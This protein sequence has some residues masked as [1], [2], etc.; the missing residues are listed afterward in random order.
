[1]VAVVDPAAELRIEIGAAA[2]PGVWGGFIQNDAATG[3]GERHRRCKP[4]EARPD[5]MHATRARRSPHNTPWRNTSQSL[6]AVDT[7]TRSVGSRHSE[8]SD[9]CHPG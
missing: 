1:M 2:S 8:R 6:S 3:L 7:P 5:D 9:A 4:G